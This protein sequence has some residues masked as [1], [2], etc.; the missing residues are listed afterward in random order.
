MLEWHGT[1]RSRLLVIDSHTEANQKL[2]KSLVLLVTF[3]IGVVY[4]E[5]R[6]EHGELPILVVYPEVQGNFN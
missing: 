2:L 4:A 5:G 1:A 3:L 6:V